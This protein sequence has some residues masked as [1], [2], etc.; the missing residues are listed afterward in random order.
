MLLYHFIRDKVLSLRSLMI[1]W[2]KAKFPHARN[3]TKGRR[4]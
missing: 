1:A 2:K 4:S 3:I